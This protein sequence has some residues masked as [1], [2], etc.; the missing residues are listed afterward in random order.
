MWRN[1]A[2]KTV[3]NANKKKDNAV[4]YDLYVNNPLRLQL[5]MALI[6]I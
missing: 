5:I 3:Q 4:L 6:I 1:Y 2:L